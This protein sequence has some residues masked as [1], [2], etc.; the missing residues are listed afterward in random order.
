MAID[1]III[2]NQIRSLDCI[3]ICICSYLNVIVLIRLFVCVCGKLKMIN[4]NKNQ[5]SYITL[6]YTYYCRIYSINEKEIRSIWCEVECGGWVS[7]MFVCLCVA[8]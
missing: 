8:N 6:P 2:N 5:N 1:K 4:K 7:C 3:C